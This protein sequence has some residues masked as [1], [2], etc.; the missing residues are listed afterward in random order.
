MTGQYPNSIPFFIGQAK[1]DNSQSDLKKE[2]FVNRIFLALGKLIKKS[3]GHAEKQLFSKWISSERNSIDFNKL[4]CS[5]ALT[6][7]FLTDEGITMKSIIE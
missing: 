5:K 4:L 2:Y 3:L 6:S 7:I 1:I